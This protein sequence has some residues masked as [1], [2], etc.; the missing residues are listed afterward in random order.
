MPEKICA[1]YLI[2]KRHVSDTLSCLNAHC[3]RNKLS[4]EKLFWK[5]EDRL[6]PVP[7]VS[8]FEVKAALILHWWT[9]RKASSH[10]GVFAILHS[11]WSFCWSQRWLASSFQNTEI[12]Q[13]VFSV[14]K[15]IFIVFDKDGSIFLSKY[16]LSLPVPKSEIFFFR[17]SL[18]FYYTL[19][20]F[21]FHVL[22]LCN[23]SYWCRC[24]FI[25][26]FMSLLFWQHLK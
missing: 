5:E 14:W 13:S 18:L 2:F 20:L 12:E 22:Y 26:F 4:S 25:F 9:F 23:T 21:Q 19:S 6:V 15:S 8:L 24:G 16:N 11:G 17:M 3:Q 7:G 1:F 10:L